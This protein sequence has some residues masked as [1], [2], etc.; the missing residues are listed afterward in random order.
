MKFDDAVQAI[1]RVLELRRISGAHVVD[2]RQLSNDELKAAIIK[3]KPQYL[4]EDTVR[5]NLETVLYKESSND[6]RVLSRLILVDVL[7]NQY[8]FELP[9][10]QTEE[11]VIAFE[12]SV[13]NRSNE[14]DLVDLAC[15]NSESPRHKNL[16]LYNF[17]LQVAWDNENTKSPDEVNLLR[18]LRDRLRIT[19]PDHRLIEAKLGKYP[20]PSNELHSRTDIHDTRSYLQ[21]FGLLF[22]T[23][24]DDG[25]DV[26]VIPEE[27]ATVIRNI[28]GLELRVDSY[29]V[30]MS[31]KAV[32]RKAHLIEVLERSG[33]ESNRYDTVDTLV[34]RILNYVPPSKA[35]ASLSPRYGLSN[36]ELAGWCRELNEPVSGT[37]DDRIQRIISH[38]D[39]LRPHVEQEVDERSNWYEF[40]EELASRNYE[41]LRSQHLI[42][43]DLEI[44]AKFEDATEFLFAEKLNHTPLQQAGSNHPDG[45]LSLGPNYLMWDNKSKESPVNLRDHLRQFD[46][47]MDQGNKPVP[48]FLVIAPAFTDDSESE[49]IRYH[50][51][52]F[53]RNITLITASE[54]K[55][56]AEEWS[57]E[58]NKT[59]DEPF[60]LGL[61]AAAGRF[62]RSRLGRL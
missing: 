16:E 48:V 5:S 40:Y 32:R 41:T 30:L 43:K 55:S 3:A 51:R 15:T 14:I 13:V 23:K 50:A 7:L 17:V 59:R 61:L 53:D 56:L 37:M 25:A 39:Q 1:S 57:S 24:R 27:L 20:N 2:H 22:A 33:I 29:R 49:A 12:Q 8:D 6:S 62:D 58:S 42:E 38:Y 46:E 21:R 45:L 44:E 18:K 36:D 47:Y 9:F 35:F 19:E 10:G 60:P 31:Y 26:D 28:L 4:H 11:Q 34:D 52:H 54:L